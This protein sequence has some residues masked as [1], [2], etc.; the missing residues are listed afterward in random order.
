MVI[1]QKKGEKMKKLL[2]VLLALLL[3]LSFTACA[4][5]DGSKTEAPEGTET[6]E[7]PD[8]PE[9]ETPE[10]KY[11][12]AIV[13]KDTADPWFLRLEEGLVKYVNDTGHMAYMKGP[14]VTDAA[15]QYTIIEELI[16][17]DIDVLGVVPVDPDIIEP[18]LQQAMDKGIIVITHE[19]P[20]QEVCD[21][22]VENFDNVGFGKAMMDEFAKSVGGKG[23]YV[24]VVSYLGN[25]THKLW[26]DTA[27]EHAKENYPELELIPEEKIEGESNMDVVYERAKEILKKYPDL[28]GFY[29]TDSFDP[30][31]IGKAIVELGLE[32][33]CKVMG[34]SFASVSEEVLKSGVCP[35]VMAWDPADSGY[36]MCRVGEM[37]LD[38]KRDELVPGADLGVEGFES[39][40]VDGK[41]ITGSGWIIVTVDNMDEYDF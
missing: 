40:G 8:E 31:G 41:L 34:C 26:T 38:G 6:Q 18:I 22:D 33:T 29:V 25:A 5:E 20:E 12:M 39:I 19:S 21:F 32:D 23:K 14:P 37:I 13:V 28:A 27:I 2:V 7:T 3:L 17:Q 24:T 4:S 30:A 15:Q 1:N 36:L 10:T 35:W 16:A 9:P 11:N